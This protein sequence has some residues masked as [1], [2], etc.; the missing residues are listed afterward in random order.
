MNGHST[1]DRSQS[2]LYHAL[3]LFAQEKLGFKSLSQVV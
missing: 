1:S 3:Y 2:K